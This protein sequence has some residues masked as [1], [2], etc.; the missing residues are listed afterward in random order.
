MRK[1]LSGCN[2][3]HYPTFAAV[4]THE[5]GSGS[6]QGGGNVSGG[7]CIAITAPV[8]AVAVAESVMV[9]V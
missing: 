7:T 2:L 6:Q 3:K 8:V 1:E 9:L 4:A 5:G